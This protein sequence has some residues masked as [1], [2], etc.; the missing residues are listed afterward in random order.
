MYKYSLEQFKTILFNEPHHEMSD[1]VL[2]KISEIALEVGSPQYIKTPVFKKETAKNDNF[3]N[4]GSGGGKKKHK[5]NDSSDG[6][7]NVIKSTVSNSPLYAA[8]KDNVDIIMALLN[9]LTA[10]N[11]DASL[12]KIKEILSAVIGSIKI[13]ENA[14][15]NGVEINKISNVIFEIVSTNIFYSQM[16]AKLFTSLVNEYDVI[17]ETM[18]DR[19]NN[20]INLFNNIEQADPNE[21]Y[22]KFC[23]ITKNNQKR[24]ALSTFF[25]NLM[26]TK[27]ISG[28]QIKNIL[29]TLV[30]SMYAL[31]QQEHKKGEV[32]ELIE[33][34]AIMYRP[35]LSGVD[36]YDEL[37]G[38][39]VAEFIK[40]VSKS[41]VAN[42]KSLSNKTI[43][44][45]MD[46][47]T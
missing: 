29:K 46:L 5:P 20:F 18:E 27:V 10:A 36:K 7:W 9:K 8:K 22:D 34:I 14:M 21:D 32:D 11:C 47:M 40:L 30:I 43:F 39:T 38:I 15:D 17:K 2:S 4:K 6:E 1:A 26:D 16:Y 3:R 42:Y 45:C 41:K 23:E 37:G 25:V 31:M 44:K 13:D 19:F 12:V 33:N 24:K 28:D 35:E